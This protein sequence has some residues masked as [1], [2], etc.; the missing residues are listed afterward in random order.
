MNESQTKQKIPMS[1]NLDDFYT[2]QEQ[3]DDE[4]KE[5]IE[6]V[7]ISLIDNFKNHPFK[8]LDN[9]E[10][11][12]LENSIKSNGL[13]EA[14]ILRP[15]QD[16]RFEMI[17]GHR[18][19]MACK[20][21]GLET[22]PSRIRDLTDDEAIIYM[23]DSNLH[24]EKLLPSEKAYAYKMKYEALR[25]QGTSLPQDSTLRPVVTKFRSD[26]ILGEE[27]G[28]SGRQVQRYIRLTNLIPKLL[29]MVDNTELKE[30]PSIAL[31]PAV[32]LSFLTKEE[33][34]MLAEYIECNLVTPSLEQAIKLK[35][36]SRG[37]ILREENIENLLDVPKANQIQKF[38]INEEKLFNVVPK[39]IER[40]KL[41]D[42]VIKA[43]EFYSKHLKN[44]DRERYVIGMT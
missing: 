42:F 30:S 35:E 6:E 38:K 4:K 39:N 31:R 11:R 16:G 20:N 40:D 33:Q 23:V 29:Q 5:K 12:T 15:K 18:R 28:E 34:K 21:L 24:R 41:E 26:D 37:G 13:M 14:V 10:M 25:H 32:E 36:L 7:N 44:K 8:V 3:R 2:T 17:S 19:L 1:F 9:E 43:C 27:H 22:I